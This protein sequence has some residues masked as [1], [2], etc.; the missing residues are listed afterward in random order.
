MTPRA[1][2]RWQIVEMDLWDRVAIDLLGPLDVLAVDVALN[3]DEP[4]KNQCRTTPDTAD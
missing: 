1:I 2:G 3:R 4:T